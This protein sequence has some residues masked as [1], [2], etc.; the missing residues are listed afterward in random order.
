MTH[1]GWWKDTHLDGKRL[2]QSTDLWI[3]CEQ[4]LDG[5]PICKYCP[6]PNQK[7]LEWSQWT[8]QSAWSQDC[9]NRNPGTSHA[10]DWKQIEVFVEIE[11]AATHTCKGKDSWWGDI[12]FSTSP[13]KSECQKRCIAKKSRSAQI[14]DWR[15]EVTQQVSCGDD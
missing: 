11:T 1:W 6:N 12:C 7:Q 15:E 5:W 9:W 13:T 14:H 8:W 4:Y 10:K 2:H 3:G